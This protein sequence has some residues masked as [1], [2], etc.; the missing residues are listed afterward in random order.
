VKPPGDKDPNPWATST[1]INVIAAKFG[2]TAAFDG[3]YSKNTYYIF[4]PVPGN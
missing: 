4:G 3:L 2:L 1:G